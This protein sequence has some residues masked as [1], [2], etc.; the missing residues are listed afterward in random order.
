MYQFVAECIRYRKSPS[1]SELVRSSA[2]VG[3]GHI[4][5]NRMCSRMAT[6]VAYIQRVSY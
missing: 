5:R 4:E 1:G 3:S 6:T 2:D